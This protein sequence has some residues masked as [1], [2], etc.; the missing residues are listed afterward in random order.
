MDTKPKFIYS[1]KLRALFLF[2]RRGA[3]SLLLDKEAHDPGGPS[4][5]VTRR[6]ATLTPKGR[7][8]RRQMQLLQA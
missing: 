6:E 7:V 2:G 8:E 3:L 1:E 4:S 5:H